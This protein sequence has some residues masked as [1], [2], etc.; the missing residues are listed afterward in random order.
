VPI[1]VGR[2]TTEVTV[3]DGDLPLSPAQLEK[4]VALVARRVEERQREQARSREAT[5]IRGHATPPVRTA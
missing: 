1:E 3:A 2:F 4:L 5:A